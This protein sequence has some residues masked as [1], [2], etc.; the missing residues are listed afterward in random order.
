MAIALISVV[1]L[2]MLGIVLLVVGEHD[3]VPDDPNRPAAYFNPQ[4]FS[5]LPMPPFRQVRIRPCSGRWQLGLALVVYMPMAACAIG[6]LW[7]FRQL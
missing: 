3:F 2:W 5:P 7:F 6:L 4:R 1:A